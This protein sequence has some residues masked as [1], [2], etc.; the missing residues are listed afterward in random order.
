MVA[1][2]PRPASQR[3]F[4]R[5]GDVTELGTHVTVQFVEDANRLDVRI[6][7]LGIEAELRAR[8]ADLTVNSYS[9]Y[10]FTVRLE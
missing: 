4:R 3:K 9:D 10:R 8:E 5:F 2:V 1:G 6:T 7:D